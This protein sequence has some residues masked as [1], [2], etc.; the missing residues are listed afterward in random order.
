MLVKI[1]FV[2]VV[3]LVIEPFDYFGIHSLSP[4]PGTRGAAQASAVGLVSG[5]IHGFCSRCGF[6]GA[7]PWDHSPNTTKSMSSIK[8]TT[9]D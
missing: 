1:A 7:L 2:F 9:H 3:C 8:T 6:C 5:D 4:D